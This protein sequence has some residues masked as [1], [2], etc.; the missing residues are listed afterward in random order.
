[1]S[2]AERKSLTSIEVIAR[3][4]KSFLRTRSIVYDVDVTSFI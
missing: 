4:L 2:S 3:T 1:M